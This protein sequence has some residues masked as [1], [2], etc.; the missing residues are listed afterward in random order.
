MW[1][2]GAIWQFSLRTRPQD[3]IILEKLVAKL[4][5]EQQSKGENQT[6]KSVT[7]SGLFQDKDPLIL[8]RFNYAYIYIIL[9]S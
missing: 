1:Q 5:S 7:C 4:R 9:F 2:D 3:C 8:K 6:D